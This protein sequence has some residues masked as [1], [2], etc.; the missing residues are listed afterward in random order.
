MSGSK[1][2]NQWFD[3]YGESHQ[4]KINKTIHWVAVPIIFL[5]VVGLLWSIPVPELFSSV[6]YL[7]WASIGMAIAILFYIRLS[8]PIAIGM[9]FISLGCLAITSWY[10]GIG[11]WAVWKMSLAIFV[12]MWVF[13]FI[14]HKIEGK[15]P[16][17]FKDIQFLLIGPAWLLHFL[18]KKAGIK[19]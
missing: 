14:G 6:P 17:F 1:T 4:N 12:V 8:F 2:A 5:T 11:H 19:Y 18:Y 9:F 10:E 3:E 15:K 13:Q 7:N 16:S